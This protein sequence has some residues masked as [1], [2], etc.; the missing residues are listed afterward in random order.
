MT[1]ASPVR[2]VVAR[3]CGT[4][5][6]GDQTAPRVAYWGRPPVFE[7]GGVGEEAMGETDTTR[8]TPDIRIGEASLAPVGVGTWSWGDRRFWGFE[9]GRDEE[10]ARQAA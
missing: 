9:A 2:P 7:P 10:D 8:A 3:H 1:C 4:V 5:R 6:G